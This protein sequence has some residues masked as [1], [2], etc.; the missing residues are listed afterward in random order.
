MNP[1]LV[2]G[3][4]FLTQTLCQ[5]DNEVLNREHIPSKVLKERPPLRE[6]AAELGPVNWHLFY[7]V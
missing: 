1:D 3:L 5:Q 6:V 7:P 4:H 2:P